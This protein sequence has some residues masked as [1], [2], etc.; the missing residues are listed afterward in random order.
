MGTPKCKNMM[1]VQKIDHLPTGDLKALQD[2]IEQKVKPQKY[3]MILHDKET[4][5]QGQPSTP[6][7]HVMMTFSS[8]RYLSAIAKLLGDKPQYIKVWSRN[9]DNG[10]AYLTHR[11]KQAQIQGKYQYDPSEVTANFDYPTYLAKVQTKAA[12]AAKQK[13]LTAKNLLDAMYA[14]ILTKSEVESHLTG[15]QLAYYKRQIDIVWHKVLQTRAEKWRKE[16]AEQGKQVT[17]IWLFGPAGAGKTRLAREI[18]AK[19]QQPYY[20]S[21]SSRDIFEDYAGEHTIILDE[22]RPKVMTYQDLLRILDP[23]GIGSSVKAPS[24]YHDK[25]LAA[26][27]III[28]SPY[29]PYGFWAEQF[30]VV[31]KH[32][33]TAHKQTLAD[34]GPDGFAQLE[35]RVSATIM[36]QP[37]TID[38][39]AF[40]DKDGCYN[41]LSSRVNPY[42]FEPPAPR[43]SSADVFNKIFDS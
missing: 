35:R 19:R 25:P 15:S 37:G 29:A 21:G 24:R 27:L 6:D 28:T 41:V 33:G 39:V 2:I 43:C 12:E 32:Q 22:L 14:G 34:Q 30:S 38:L 11:T 8:S 4:D 13:D 3:A 26:D 42:L 16:M 40:S 18:A 31:V 7:V 10:Y 23:F 9:E 20:V 1:Y 17:V 36:V 5:A